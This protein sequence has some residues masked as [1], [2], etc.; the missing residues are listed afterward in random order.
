M[1]DKSLQ[2]TENL[3]IEG[4]NI[5]VGEWGLSFKGQLTTEE[6]LDAILKLQ[7]Y[8]GKIQWYLGDLAVYAESPTTGWGQ[9]KYDQ[10][11]ALTGYDYQTLKDYANVSRRFTPSFREQI[12]SYITTDLKI[13]WNHFRAS[14]S[15]DDVQATY[16]LEKAN[17][18]GW[19]VAKLREEIRKWKETKQISD[20]EEEGDY[21]PTLAQRMKEAWTLIKNV[22]ELEGAETIRIQAVRG[23]KVIDEQLVEL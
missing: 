5:E 20:K 8:D 19:G 23:G 9:S 15:L 2:V 4:K 16:W 1:S 13:S 10:L 6:W 17:N 18:N 21:I 14:A 22:A 7:K 3:E 12:G 11:L